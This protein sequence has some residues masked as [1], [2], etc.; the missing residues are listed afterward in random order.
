[1]DGVI[2]HGRQLINGVKSFIAWLQ[3]NKKQF[4]FLTNNSNHTVE[5]LQE[6]LHLLGVDVPAQH[7]YTSALATAE[8]LDRQSPKSSA[9]V[10]GGL[11]LVEAIESIGYQ[12]DDQNP[13]YV[14]VGDPFD[15]TYTHLNLAVNLVRKGAK[16]IGTN[17]D[18]TGPVEGGVTLGTG[19]LVAAIE[20]AAQSKAYYVGKP[21]PLIMRQ[22]MQRLGSHHNETVIIGDRMDTDI[23]AGVETEVTTVLV[24]S[25]LTKESDLNHYAYQ[26][27]YVLATVGEIV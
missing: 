6:K 9:Y 3:E 14:V 12:H 23:I 4:I 8:F 24:L 25:G 1:M 5:T 13:E 15:L 2:Y 20:L 16:L 19:A 22:A 7:F 18:L 10:I 21:N 17:P 26:P 27:D 11:G